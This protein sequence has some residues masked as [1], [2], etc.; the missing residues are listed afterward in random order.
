M[1]KRD[2]TYDKFIELRAA[3]VE[4]I[5]LAWQN[6]DFKTVFM[7]NPKKFMKKHLDYDFPFNMILE[8]DDES[9]RKRTWQP[10]DTG[11]WVGPNNTLEMIL[12]PKP[13][14]DTQYGDQQA[15]ALSSYN[16][17]HLT[18]FNL[19]RIINLDKPKKE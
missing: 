2:A 17:D 13:I 19:E 3:I 10:L 9:E 11:G 16:A 5:A 6:N 4:S 12:P 18:M 14:F 8:I 15:V 1:S 7:E